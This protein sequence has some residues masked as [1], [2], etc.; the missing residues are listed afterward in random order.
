MSGIYISGMEMPESCWRCEIGN[1]EQMDN[2]PCPFYS[3]DGEEQKKY[4][5]SR[6][7]DCP[8]IPVPDHGDL[9]DKQY[10]YQNTMTLGEHTRKIVLKQIDALPVVIPADI[11]T[12]YYPQVDG[13][14]PTVIK[15]KKE[16][17]E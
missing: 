16:E 15:P 14:T 13:I 10:A 5:D 6:H 11:K 9:I 3:I 8:L 2:R 1:A 4:A 17:T 12:M 7:P